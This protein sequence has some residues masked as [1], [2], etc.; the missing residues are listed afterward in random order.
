MGRIGSS[1]PAPTRHAAMLAHNVYFT[2][3][4][5]S[6]AARQ[7]LLAA[8]NKYL[9]KHPGRCSSPPGWLSAEGRGQ[10]PRLRRGAHRHL[11]RSDC[12]RPLPGRPGP[13]PVHRGKQGQLEEGAASSTRW[14][15]A[16][17]PK[18]L[19]VGAVRGIRNKAGLQRRRK[20]GVVLPAAWAYHA[21][22]RPR[23][24]ILRR[25]PTVTRHFASVLSSP[26]RASPPSP[27][28]RPTPP[29][30]NCSP[31]P[32]RPAPPR[33]TSPASTRRWKS[34][35]TARSPRRTPS[36]SARRAK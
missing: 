2:L 13:P 26:P 34:T 18:P 12:P 21:P 7:Q 16:V 14:S 9:S 28:T 19:A 32:V 33:T 20:N 29:R 35:S 17:S 3:K 24:A 15:K 36:R 6:A 1:T 10:R 25:P 31:T 30:R 22:G 11:R 27:P 8:C 4:D 5:N 23:N